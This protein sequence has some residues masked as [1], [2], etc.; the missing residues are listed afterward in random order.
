MRNDRSNRRVGRRRFLGAVPAAVAAGLSA[1]GLARQAPPDTPLR[2]GKDALKCAE[3]IAGLSFTDAEEE[4]MRRGVTVNREHY[5]TLRKVQIPADTEPAFSFRLP[6]PRRAPGTSRRPAGRAS[7][8]GRRASSRAASASAPASLEDLAFLPVTA[9][10]PLVEA[11]KV[12]STEL[13]RMYLAR[14][15]KYD[16]TLKAV[17]TLTDEL[18]LAQAAEADREIRAGRYRGPLHGIPWGVKDLFATTG[19]RTTWGAK[20]YERQV[21]DE[22]ATAVA[23]LREAGAVLVAKLSTGELA[24]GDLWF[25]GRT[26]NP[27]NPERGS[28]GSSAGPASAAAAGLVGF[29]VGTETGGSIISPAS[30]C[31]VVGLRPTY[32]RVSRRG[33]MTLRWTLDKVG[34][35]CRGVEDCAIVLDAIVGP[36]GHDE[37]V[38]DLPF[39]WQPVARVAGLR[40]GYVEPEFDAPPADA[41]EEDRKKWP[42]RKALL[43]DALDVFR[44]AGARVE[45]MALPDLPGRA[46]YAILNAEAGAAFD[47]LVRSG[48]VAE[49]AGKGAADRANQLRLS[50]LIPAVEY[51][52]AQRARTLLIR[53]MNALFDRYDVFLAPPDSASVMMTNL[54]GHPAVTLKA[55]FADGLPQ[56]IM[57]TG[58]LYD[59]A[60]ILRA[61][62]AFERATRWHTMHPALA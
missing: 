8:T 5:E 58:R 45:P 49:L 57:I 56:A 22:D 24:Y 35:L 40:V 34:P 12:S 41:S 4:L 17:V 6:V 30:R 14:L 16:D 48:A 2:F 47:D 23:R 37:T 54:T 42:T 3:Q 15:K 19:I 20:P 52:Q 55:G 50:R 38:A 51:I 13:T 25:G 39:D 33:V 9:L 29:A 1:P 44:Q 53:Q 27:W 18:A 32:G 31:G 62:L 21:F 36:D 26:R 28:S 11:R 61:A 60:T 46:L 10:A 43:T 59:E 7:S